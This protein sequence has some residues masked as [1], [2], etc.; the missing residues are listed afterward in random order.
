[1]LSRRKPGAL[2]DNGP[3]VIVAARR[4]PITVRGGGLSHLGAEQLAGPVVRECVTDAESAT[5]QRAQVADVVLGNCMGPGGNIGRISA[6]AAG[7]DSSVPGMSI[8]RQ[9]GSGLSA[10]ITAGEAIRAGDHR[11]RIAGGVE[12][13]STAPLRLIAGA[14]YT[15][16]PFA[17][18]GFPDPE[19]GPAAEALAQMFGISRAHQ[20]DYARRSHQRALAAQRRQIFDA[21]I[22]SVDG[23]ANDDG[24][25]ENVS[26]L[27]SRFVPLFADAS[28]HADGTV[29]AGNSCRIC[30]GAAAVAMVPRSAR[31]GAP[32]LALVAASTIGCDPA[33]P[34]IGPVAAVRRALHD[35]NVSLSQ[36]SA[37]E[38]VEAFSAQTLAVLQS[39]DLADR[40]RVDPR[41]CA[42]GG[43]LA[44]GHPWG[45]SGAVGVV[46]L[47]SRLVRQDAPAGALGLAT[48]AIGGGMG[49]AA[50]FE[51][52]R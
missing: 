6:L 23:V 4:T 44:L 7:L 28:G 29:T 48:A 30:D 47:F 27:L 36:I 18:T 42:D 22:V 17:P 13:A 43:A 46:R 52:V 26:R 15:R 2:T 45:A 3:A 9:C 11:M 31:Q 14:P 1:M 19:M 34:G 16:A 49:V 33:L 40:H 20:D 50:V 35:A 25:R 38:I 24:P 10:I 8:D 39:L 32:G 12:S 21:E 5:G 51:V 37:I 41:V